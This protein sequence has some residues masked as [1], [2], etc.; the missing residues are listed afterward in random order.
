M[1]TTWHDGHVAKGTMHKHVSMVACALPGA[2][3]RM[4]SLLAGMRRA[5][6]SMTCGVMLTSVACRSTWGQV[7][8]GMVPLRADA[9]L[10]G[11]AAVVISWLITTC[12][13]RRQPGSSRRG[14]PDSPR[15]GGRRRYDVFIINASQQNDFAAW[16]RNH[17]RSCGYHSYINEHN[18]RCE[19]SYTVLS[20]HCKP[21]D[22][23][24]WLMFWSHLR[25]LRRPQRM[26][27]SSPLQRLTHVCCMSC[28]H[29]DDDPVKREA[30]LRTSSVVLV[31]VTR[32]L[33]R[34][35]SCMEELSWAYDEQSRQ[36]QQQQR[37]LRA[38]RA[39]VIVPIFYHGPNGAVDPGMNYLREA[40]SRSLL[41]ILYWRTASRAERTRW[42]R[43]LLLLSQRPGIKREAAPRARY[44]AC[45]CCSCLSRL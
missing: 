21:T 28:R 41:L 4:I 33:I 36:A 27:W 2:R 7:F 30:A 35:S 22:V 43:N 14:Q 5:H 1:Q 25:C 37:Q 39:S 19:R 34:T 16:I 29:G 44:A 12:W 13:P 26:S 8:C 24:S 10:I 18:L 40:A 45:R 17:V 20:T 42:H 3:Q 9:A 31:V 6:Q 23:M 15:Y 38:S 32:D 11:V